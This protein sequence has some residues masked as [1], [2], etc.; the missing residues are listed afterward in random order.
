V[1]RVIETVEIDAPPEEVWKVVADP[2]NLPRWDRR[3]VK[4]HGAPKSGIEEGSEYSTI[5][6]FMGVRA[7]VDAE[8]LEVKPP[9]YSRIKLSGPVLD[10]IVTTRV[11]PTDDGRTRLEHVVDYEMRGGPIGRFAAKALDVIGG[12]SMMLR[13]GAQAQKHQIENG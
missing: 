3:I 1:S 6:S 9:E 11:S 13:R 12:P 4:V 8:V 10:A 5:M 7:H 2:R